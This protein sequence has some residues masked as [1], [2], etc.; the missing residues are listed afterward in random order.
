MNLH[1]DFISW[2]FVD[3]ILE[4]EKTASPDLDRARYNRN[5]YFM[6]MYPYLSIKK[7]KYYHY[8]LG[9]LFLIRGF[10]RMSEI[11]IFR[12]FFF[13]FPH[14]KLIYLHLIQLI[15]LLSIILLKKN[16][17]I[18]DILNKLVF[19]LLVF[20]LGFFTGPFITFHIYIFIPVGTSI[21]SS[22]KLSHVPL[23]IVIIFF[24]SFYSLNIFSY[25]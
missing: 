9:L 12:D 18:I 3:P 1:S 14:Q 19:L 8:T 2:I 20:A 22:F 25:P 4:I 17:A 10:F 11:T 13:F 16:Q 24:L 7:Y 23:V 6:L 21:Q 15:G 5:K